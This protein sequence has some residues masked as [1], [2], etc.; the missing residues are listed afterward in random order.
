MQDE[1]FMALE[2]SKMM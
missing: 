1:T 2:G